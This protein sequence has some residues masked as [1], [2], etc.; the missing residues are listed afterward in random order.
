MCLWR[1]SALVSFI[2][3][4]FIVKSKDSGELQVFPL[5]WAYNS[6]PSEEEW[7]RLLPQSRFLVDARISGLIPTEGRSAVLVPIFRIY[8]QSSQ[9]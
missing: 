9:K 3:L 8:A 7:N 2:A 1:I 6:V 4:N 5:K